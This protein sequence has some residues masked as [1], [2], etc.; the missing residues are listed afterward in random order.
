MTITGQVLF[1]YPRVSA[2]SQVEWSS[3][4]ALCPCRSDHSQLTPQPH[5]P[6]GPMEQFT[7]EPFPSPL[8]SIT[9][10]FVLWSLLHFSMKKESVE[11]NIFKTKKNISTFNTRLL[12]PE[13][14]FFLAF[15]FQR[16][17]FAHCE[18]IPRVPP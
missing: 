13:K 2:S 17:C 8:L 7:E 12:T 15:I 10:L 5:P 4:V 11:R 6:G 9:A 18:R 3:D 16:Y 1:S 14:T